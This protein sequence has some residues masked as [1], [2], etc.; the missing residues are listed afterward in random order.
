MQGKADLTK[1]AGQSPGMTVCGEF[2]GMDRTRLPFSA[3]GNAE[4][5]SDL[6]VAEY[7]SVYVQVSGRRR[8]G[9]PP[10]PFCFTSTAESFSPDVS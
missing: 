6:Q 4:I 8:P 9:V 3:V 10:G 1:V 5:E 2:V 7:C